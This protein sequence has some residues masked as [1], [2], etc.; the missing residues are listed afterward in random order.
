M[1]LRRYWM[2]AY[3][4]IWLIVLCVVL[5]ITGSLGASWL[6]TPMYEATSTLRI[7]STATRSA[8][9]YTDLLAGQRLALTYAQLL[10][11][12]PVLEEVINKLG[13]SM[14]TKQLASMIRIQTVRDTEL[15]RITVQ[16]ADPVVIQSIANAIPEVFVRQD[17]AMEASRYTK[18]KQSLENK[19]AEREEEIRQ[20]QIAIASKK[21]LGMAADDPEIIRLETDQEQARANYV[22]LLQNYGAV[23]LAEA[24][25]GSGVMI[26]AQARL[27]TSPVGPNRVQIAL[28]AAAVGLAVG[29]GAILLIEYL[30]DTI[31]TGEDVQAFL[32]LATLGTVPREG[33]KTAGPLVADH[34]S[35]SV[36]AEAYRVLRTNIRTCNVDH[37]VTSLLVTSSSSTEGKSTTAANLGV[38]MAESGQQVI[39]VDADLRRPT[40]HKLFDLPNASGLTSALLD[41]TEAFE[42]WLLETKVHNL[43]LLTSGPTPPIPSELLGSQRM[44]RLIA[45]LNDIA[46]VVIYDSPPTLG[47]ADT[48]ILAEQVDGTLLIVD[49][50]GTR[51]K[52]GQ[53]SLDAL[54]KVGARVIGVALNKVNLKDDGY[55][56]RYYTDYGAKDDLA[57]PRRRRISRIWQ[58]LFSR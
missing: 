8:S 50:G 38:V 3:K 10:T 19:I 14:T 48:A 43:R 25:T 11:E 7:S 12:A 28:L 27:P 58:R 29:L 35:Q 13:L 36:L 40:L 42:D 52:L 51:R 9:N 21:A 39:L 16:G 53:Q 30:D 45:H 5:A 49:S 37:P 15:I 24:Q 4:R 6:K 17:Q 23:E 31:K 55:Y 2:L 20:S 44:Q 47:I 22:M 1:E 32:G 57:K 41:D 46:D 26:V 18:L 33:N 54:T 34:L 56:G